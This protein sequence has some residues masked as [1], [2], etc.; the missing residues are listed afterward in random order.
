MLPG[1]VGRRQA[2]VAKES[3]LVGAPA[4]T[5]RKLAM[6]LENRDYMRDPG[7]G[8]RGIYGSQRVP[9][10]P[11][12]GGVL[13]LRFISFNTWLIIVNVAI[14]V[15]G[16]FLA[17]RPSAQHVMSMTPKFLPGVTDAER[18]K[19]LP[20]WSTFRPDVPVIQEIALV[21]PLGTG[22]AGGTLVRDIGRVQVYSCDPLHYYGH[23]ST[24]K[25][26]FGYEVW[27]FVTFQFLHANLTHLIFNMLGLWFVGGLVESYLGSKRYA[28]F[29]LTAGI[30]GAV[31]Y[32][33]LNFLG[34]F[35]F[36]GMHV[37][38]LL[39][40][41]PQTPLVGASAG[42]FGVLMAAAF[43]AP[44]AIVDVFGLIP[45]K[46]KTAVYVFTAIALFNLVRSSSNAGGEAAHIGGALAGYYFIRRTHLLRDFFDLFGD[47]RREAGRDGQLPAKGRGVWPFTGPRA[48]PEQAEVNRILDKVSREGLSALAEAEKRTLRLASEAARR[49]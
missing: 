42:I 2:D 31:A 19:A 22:P 4:P 40:D 26:F 3:R 39:F 14:F 15:L 13:S 29:Y 6:G 7:R 47:S 38:G 8:G 27:R 25:A 28:A 1:P 46:M 45:V 37:P 11:R 35:V 33:L 12:G 44:T 9:M 5:A 10:G 17:T 21:V 30:F 18:A 43:I 32:L 48:A 20:D 16:S 36:R 41:D 23:F 24:A 34:H 49:G